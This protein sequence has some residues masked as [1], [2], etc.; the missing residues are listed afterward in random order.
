MTGCEALEQAATLL[1]GVAEDDPAYECCCEMSNLI[2]L[3]LPWADVRSG[4]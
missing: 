3:I 4:Q 2:R 1:E